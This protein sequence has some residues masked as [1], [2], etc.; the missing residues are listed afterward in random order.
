ML[1]AEKIKK[2]LVGLGKKLT[3]KGLVVGPGGNTSVRLGNIVYM[4]ASGITF[5]E[6]AES[7]YIGVDLKTG[8]VV[9]GQKKPTCEILMH[10]GCYLGRKDISAV[11]HTHPPYAIAYAMLGKTLKQFTPDFVAIIN[12]DVPVIKYVIPAGKELA[13]EVS[14]TIKKYNA[15]LMANHGLLTVGANLKEAYYRTQFIEDS[16]KTV[17]SA[18]SLGKMRYFSDDEVNAVDNL[19]AEDYRRTLLKMDGSK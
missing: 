19:E 2:E 4:K 1:N 11:V 7:D 3:D 15:V 10:L 12:S 9:D 5:E 18:Q 6:A 17:I 13:D 16:C 8:E 14:K